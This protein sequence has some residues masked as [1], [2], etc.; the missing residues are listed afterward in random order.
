MT[1]AAALQK[2][3]LFFRAQRSGDLGSDNPIP[4]RR[5]PS[6]A[7]DGSDV[8]VDLSKGYFDAGDYVKYGLPGA[9]SMA[10]LAWSGLEFADGF[11]AAGS[12]DELRSAVRWG[13]DFLLA[14]SEHLDDGCTFYAQVGR[15]AAKGCGDDSCRYD[16]GFWG[17]P[18][19]YE[20]TYAFAS[21]RRTYAV[22][23]SRP[24]N[25]YWAQASAA[26]AASSMF[27]AESDAKYAAAL[28][29]RSRRLFG[30]ATDPSI[31]PRNETLQV[32]LPE[33]SPQYE[34]HG[35]SD[36]LGWAAAWLYAATAEPQFAAAFEPGMR[37]GEDRWWY[38]GWSVSWDDVN[39]L[40]KLRM[41][42]AA[43]QG[44][45]DG[46]G[47]G[48]GDGDGGS[49]GDGAGEGAY[50]HLDHLRDDVRTFVRK[51][52][53]CAGSPANPPFTTGCGLCWLMKWGSVRYAL[54]AALLCALYAKRF[55]EDAE[56]AADAAAFARHQMMYALGDNPLRL[57]YMIGYD[58]LSGDLAYPRR[59][60][61]RAAS[62]PPRD[63]LANCSDAQLSSPR[64][65]PWVLHGAVVG[66]PDETDCWNDDRGNWVRNEVAM[67]YNAP[68]PGVLAWL[69]ETE[70]DGGDSGDSGKDR[71]AAA[72]A[73]AME[74]YRTL[75]FR[76]PAGE[77]CADRDGACPA[78][79][80]SAIQPSCPFRAS[81]CEPSPPAPPPS[82]PSPPSPPP[83]LPP[84]LP[85]APP[86]PPA[87]PP[88]S[89]D[90]T[91]PPASPPPSPAPALP[92]QPPGPP[93][94]PPS[95]LLPPSPASPP[96]SP[97]P[98]TAPPP[99][100][101]PIPSPP[102]PPATP[103]PSVPPPSAP[104][105]PTPPPPPPPCPP[106]SPLPPPPSEPPRPPPPPPSPP[107]PPP[108]P[109]PPPP[110]NPPVFPLLAQWPQPPPPAP[111]LR[112]RAA[113]RAP[114]YALALATLG[115]GCFV[116]W[117]RRQGRRENR[118]GH[119]GY[120][121][122]GGNRIDCLEGEAGDMDISELEER[123]PVV[124]AAARE[125]S[126]TQPLRPKA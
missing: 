3:L 67:D 84:P 86:P 116:A 118:R 44:D 97:P 38:E 13:A 22:N 5:A 7:H 77:E 1:L 40:A 76:Q 120:K 80:T 8:G 92:P 10:L 111:S 96:S 88:P 51:W 6:F 60:H 72:A 23:A 122:G 106:P 110:S 41:V 89:P 2:S 69:L 36:E 64:A 108:P 16:H 28:L 58:G 52:S 19:D 56:L 17:R 54:S 37:R 18:E 117:I 45:G 50:A 31:N 103:P 94:L 126:D 35:F 33:A 115:G 20:S 62:C 101:S 81:P 15:G 123:A 113:A 48:G 63:E 53:A 55:P 107:P 83:K 121:S 66:G 34:S 109:N 39:S 70:A 26:L 71:A 30:C 14:A 104:L 74:A 61:H 32:Y 12:L 119:K 99:P 25:E 112:V 4:Y 65:S 95:P 42:L 82:S 87:P 125:N 91:A 46:G 47:D 98:P 59:P 29:E 24:G 73:D 102:S 43:Q 68:V 78:G 75:E 49:D 105:P 100:F 57:S 124:L 27:L 90:P 93:A 79:T 85:S 11:A 21:Q 114:L 9:Y